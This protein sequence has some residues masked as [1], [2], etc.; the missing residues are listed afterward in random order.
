MRCRLVRVLVVIGHQNT[1]VKAIDRPELWPFPDMPL[2]TY[3]IQDLIW[4][5]RLPC[6]SLNYPSKQL[7]P[8]PV[9]SE[10][11]WL[12]ATPSAAVHR[13]VA[14]TKLSEGE[15]IAGSSQPRDPR[16]MVGAK[17][18]IRLRDVCLWSMGCFLTRS[19]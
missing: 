7:S 5:T 16:A 6:D 4:Q 11:Q 1:H 10:V 17:N 8:Q 15:V 9:S 19:R 13:A 12:S 2:A 14:W 3:K 18:A